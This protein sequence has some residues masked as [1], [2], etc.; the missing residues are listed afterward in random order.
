MDKIYG[1][2]VRQDGLYKIGRKSYTLFYGL[3][4]DDQGSNYEYRCSFDHKPTWDEV[5]AVLIETI[6]AQTKEKILNGFTWNDMKVWLS[7]DN[8][9]N[10]MMIS[11]FGDDSFPLQVKIN[12]ESDGTPIYHTFANAAEFNEFSQQ[13]SQY[14]IETWIA[15][16]NEKDQLDAATFGF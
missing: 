15:G 6:N 3:Y 11:D 9:R 14:V 5:K 4:T 8:Q 2:T 10:F 13:A 7:E 16:W 1:T 12:E